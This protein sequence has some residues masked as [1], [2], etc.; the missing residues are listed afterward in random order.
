VSGG[1]WSRLR[2]LIGAAVLIIA[3]LPSHAEDAGVPV[4]LQV[5]LP[6]RLLWNERGL[7]QSL[8]KEVRALIIERARDPVSGL[9]AAQLAAQLEQVKALGGKRVVQ[10]RVIFE[11]PEQVGRVVQEQRPY[12]AYLTPNLAPVTA[13]LSRV[14]AARGVLSVSTQGADTGRGVVLGF[15]LESGKPRILLNLVQARAQKLDFS[16]QFLRVVRVVP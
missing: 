13:E 5:E 1:I 15:E 2:A 4:A 6:S 3:A 10:R 9:A 11:S 8:Q 7:Q 16:A 12:L 14:L